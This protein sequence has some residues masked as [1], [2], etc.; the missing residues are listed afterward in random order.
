MKRKKD[1]ALVPVDLEV[2]LAPQKAEAEQALQMIQV[3][4]LT[5]QDRRDVAGKVL[6]EIR[7]RRKALEDQRKDITGPILEGKRRVDALFK[8]IDEYW[9]VC[10]QALAWRLLEATKAADQAQV[11]AL[12]AV[13]ASNGATDT[14]TLV[15]AHTP[16]ETPAGLDLRKS[17]TFRVIDADRV[18][19]EYWR[20]DEEKIRRVVQAARGEIE[21]P[22]VVVEQ[23]QSFARSRV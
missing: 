1:V 14:A 21:I 6:V 4:D 12:A 19:D 7:T 17:W 9:A 15:T 16:A 22:G 10:D 2:S 5:T 18:P 8:P 13:A 11:K 3:L 23:E 20:I